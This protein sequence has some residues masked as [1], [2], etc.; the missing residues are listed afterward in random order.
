MR[1]KNKKDETKVS[2]SDDIS[3]VAMGDS[4]TIGLGVEENERWP[5]ILTKRLREKGV[6]IT[7]V[8]NIGVSGFTS[9]DVLEKQVKDVENLGPDFVT[10]LVGANDSFKGV[11]PKIFESNLQQI[12]DRVEKALVKKTIWWF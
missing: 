12:L 4:Y 6:N 8:K 11:D 2:G 9:E 1:E 7:L 3:Y 5:N 10:I